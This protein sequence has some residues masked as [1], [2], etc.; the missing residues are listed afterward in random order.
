[1]LAR[2]EA[3]QTALVAL[4]GCQIEDKTVR[5]SRTTTRMTG[6]EILAFTEEGLKIDEK[7]SKSV[8]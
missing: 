7:L 3:A 2:N 6:E 1:V 8:N 4:T 5:V